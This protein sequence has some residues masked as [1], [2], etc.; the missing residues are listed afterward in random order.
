MQVTA[1][2]ITLNALQWLRLHTSRMDR[3]HTHVQN[4][5]TAEAARTA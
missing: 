2:T 1:Q 4:V 5:P 3:V